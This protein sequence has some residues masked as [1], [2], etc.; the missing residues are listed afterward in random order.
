VKIVILLKYT[1]DCFLQGS[2]DMTL[3]KLVKHPSRKY[4]SRI[5]FR[6]IFFVSEFRFSV[7]RVVVMI[8]KWS[9]EIFKRSF[10]RPFCVWERFTLIKVNWYHTHTEPAHAH[11]ESS[12]LSTG[13]FLLII[14]FA[15]FVFAQEQIYTFLQIIF[16]FLLYTKL[17]YYYYYYFLF[18]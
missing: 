2:K 9:L 6:E 5:T 4:I 8:H 12:T 14:L 1:A 13:I 7:K 18:L 3:W 11:T 10:A 16:L 17:F 15:H